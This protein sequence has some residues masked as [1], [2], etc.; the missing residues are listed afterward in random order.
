VSRPTRKL[1]KN[2][3]V[4]CEGDTE[5]NY[6]EGLKKQRTLHIKIKAIDMDGGGYKNFLK[7]IKQESEANC[8]AKF[9]LI[10]GDRALN[11]NKEKKNLMDIIKYCKVQNDSKRCPH[12]LIVNHPD[13]EYVACSHSTHFGEQNTSV[14][15]RDQLNYNSV[16]EFKSDVNVYTKL[17]KGD[18]SIDNMLYLLKAKPHVIKN[19]IKK[20]KEQF[21]IL[22]TG[23]TWVDE[24]FGKKGSN[25]ED[26][27]GVINML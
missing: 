12:I 18:N 3:K 5:Y 8:L 25:I 17:T 22:V 21:S 1:K 26:F 6:I 14:F 15:I 20:A 19:V 27:F 2:Y 24:A 9:I 10:D 23:P 16:D 7:K 4:F 11:D 13:F